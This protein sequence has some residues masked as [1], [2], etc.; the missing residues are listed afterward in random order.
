[1]DKESIH[2]CTQ[3]FNITY[4]HLNE[5]EELVHVCK[6]C[7]SIE[8]F[9]GKTNCIYSI[10]YD[11]FDVSSLINSNKYINHDITLPEIK[12]NSNLKCPNSECNEKNPESSFKYIKYDD[13]DMRYIYICNHCGQKWNN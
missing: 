9:T 10:N 3:C 11:D 2:F 8:N 7:S 13:N 4:L 1:M 5:K 12:G 6:V